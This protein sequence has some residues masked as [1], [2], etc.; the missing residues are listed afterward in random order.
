MQTKEK[1]VIRTCVRPNQFHPD[2]IFI[3]P[4]AQSSNLELIFEDNKL[5]EVKV[6][7]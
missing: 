1:R 5:V 4:G 7:A 3:V 6:L 2:A